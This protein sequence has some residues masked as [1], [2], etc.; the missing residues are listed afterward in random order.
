MPEQKK[1]YHNTE[2]QFNIVSKLILKFPIELQV[3]KK[4]KE[5]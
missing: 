1:I 3:S 2:L 4:Q 5:D